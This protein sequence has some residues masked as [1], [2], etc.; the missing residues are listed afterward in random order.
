MR[1]GGTK[2]NII[3]L[4]LIFVIV[5]YG[6]AKF[7]GPYLRKEKFEKEMENFMRRYA[8]MGESLMIADLIKQAEVIGLPP[9]T[10]D[11]FHFE[12]DVGVDS[13]LTCTY[14]EQIKFPGGKVYNWQLVA[15]KRMKIPAWEPGR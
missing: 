6:T 12:G 2:F 8:R 13:V 4:L 7:G 10:K 3:I 9:L 14:V 5:G 11:N 15:E 1:R